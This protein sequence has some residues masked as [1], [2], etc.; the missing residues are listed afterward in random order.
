[1]RLAEEETFCSVLQADTAGDDVGAGGGLSS[2]ERLRAVFVEHGVPFVNERGVGRLA[3]RWWLRSDLEHLV[4]TLDRR[5]GIDGGACR[6]QRLRA[7]KGAPNRRR[8][9]AVC[10]L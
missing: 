6:P 2:T 9:A 3:A 8:H 5:G 4:P 10:G 7:R 1:M